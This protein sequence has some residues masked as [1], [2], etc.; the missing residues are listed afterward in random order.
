MTSPRLTAMEF[1]KVEAM[2][3]SNQP[4]EQKLTA[5]PRPKPRMKFGKTTFGH[6][7]GIQIDFQK[8]GISPFGFQ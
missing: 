5:G 6:E 2:K 1:Q 4:F 8:R 7:R 3:Q